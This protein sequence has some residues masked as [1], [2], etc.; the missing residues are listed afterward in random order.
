M[1]SSPCETRHIGSARWLALHHHTLTHHPDTTTR[2]R[3]CWCRE[4]YTALKRLEAAN[5]ANADSAFMCA[6]YARAY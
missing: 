6:R 1:L 2:A 4:A 3:V 5:Y